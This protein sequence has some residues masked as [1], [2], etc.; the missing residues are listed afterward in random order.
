M[1]KRRRAPKYKN[2]YKLE[3]ELCDVLISYAKSNGWKVYPET[4][5]WDI[6]LVKDIQIGIQAKLKDNVDVLSQAIEGIQSA[7]VNIKFANPS[8]HLRAVLVPR[9]SKEFRKVASALGVFIIEGVSLVW[10]Y[11][12][13]KSHWGKEIKTSLDGYNKNY[14]IVPKRDCWVPEVEINVPA[15]VRSPRIITEWKIKAVKLCFKLNEKGYLTSK[16]FKDVKVSMVI[17]KIKKWLVPAEK[18]GKLMKYVKNPNAILP[19]MLYPEI[20][21][22]LQGSSEK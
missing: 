19:D 3:S 7:N 17:W 22:A 2:P 1:R 21:E 16:D 18:N 15:G 10:N 4:A 8:P 12:T 5:G 9:A 14:L 6:L 13:V 11:K 20:V